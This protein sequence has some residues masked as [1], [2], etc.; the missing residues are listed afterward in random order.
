MAVG[1]NVETAVQEFKQFYKDLIEYVQNT[2]DG[3]ELS[4]TWK[5]HIAVCHISPF[6]QSIEHGL[7]V[8]FE[9]TGEAIHHELKKNMEQIQTKSQS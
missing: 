5:V 4:V 3:F 9:Q 2:F 1:E 6:L 8:Y 7:G